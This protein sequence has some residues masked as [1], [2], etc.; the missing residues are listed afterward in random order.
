MLGW[1]RE[2]FDGLDGFVVDGVLGPSSGL[3]SGCAI[4]LRGRELLI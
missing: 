2:V 4:S 1:V 3:I